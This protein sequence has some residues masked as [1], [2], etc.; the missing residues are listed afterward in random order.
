MLVLDAAEQRKCLITRRLAEGALSFELSVATY[1]LTCLVGE[2]VEA[3]T[4]ERESHLVLYAALLE[5][6]DCAVE[7]LCNRT[8]HSQYLA[9][10][11]RKTRPAKAGKARARAR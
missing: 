5:R 1:R 10:I 4:V 11:E 7:S 3:A 9:S 8:A 2:L 6:A